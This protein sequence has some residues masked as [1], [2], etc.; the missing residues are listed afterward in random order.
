MEEI[1]Q[2]IQEL[3]KSWSGEDICITEVLPDSGSYRK[4]FRIQGT[5]KSC[6][7]VY[8]KDKK[9]NIAFTEYAK[10]FFSKG[11]PV[12]EIYAEDQDNFIYL[13]E[14]LG[15]TMLF[16]ILE[17]AKETKS[18]PQELLVLL[19][20]VLDELLKFQIIGGKDLDYSVAYPRPA[21]DRQ[22]IMWD[23]NYFKYNFLKLAKIPFHEQALEED[24]NKF[25]DFLLNAD[26]KYFLYRDFQSRNIMIKEGK[27]YFIDFQG[28]RQ[29]A[30]AYDLA[31]LIYDVAVDFPDEVKEELR[32]YYIQ[33]LPEYSISKKEFENHYVGY[34]LVRIMQAMGAF[35]F[36]GLH[37]KKQHFIESIPY[38]VENLKNL[39]NQYQLPIELPELQ[40]VFTNI[41]EADNLPKH[42]DQS[43]FEVTIYSFSFL[44]GVPDD[45]SGNGGGF[46]F[47]C[48]A[49][50]NPGRY[51]QF[52]NHTGKD[53]EV[54]DFLESENDMDEFL[55]NTFPLVE[56]AIEKQH[57]RSSKNLMVAFG[58]TG[59]QHRSVYAAE[60]LA[61]HLEKN[62]NIK[63]KLIHREQNF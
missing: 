45:Y 61:K 19:K 40:K 12:P 23:L 58:C 50:H 60:K 10:H 43:K 63:I 2:K 54:K 46:V 25:M 14:D 13:Q 17:K 37:E 56:K 59:G 62:F 18:Y 29:G 57:Q 36:R 20:Q 52:F 32:T 24:F 49:I 16:E 21:F 7:A 9:E 4:Y 26:T 8:N 55:K 11:L 1:Q 6:I 39:L 3:F 15:N 38:A 5:T 34:V 35:G 48:R 31:S 28:G 22:S 30:L 53:Q 42:K 44:K 41:I 47:D 33:R 27:P 51:K